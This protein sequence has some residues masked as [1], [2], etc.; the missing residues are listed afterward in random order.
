M[1][2]L[3]LNE[4]EKLLLNVKTDHEWRK[5]KRAELDAVIKAADVY[6]LGS[7][8]CPVSALDEPETPLSLMDLLRDMRAKLTVKEW[9]R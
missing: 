7:A 6:L 5:Q 9:G 4:G 3:F 2:E 8:Y 1:S